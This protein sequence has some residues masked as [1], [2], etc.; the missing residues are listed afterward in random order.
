MTRSAGKIP[1]EAFGKDD[2]GSYLCT[3]SSII[4]DLSSGSFRPCCVPVTISTSITFIG[5]DHVS[6]RNIV[7]DLAKDSKSAI[8]FQAF[9]SQSS[10]GVSIL[11]G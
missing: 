11:I 1:S 8:T 10:V 6:I 4:S 3:A 9:I 7:A 2:L 5:S